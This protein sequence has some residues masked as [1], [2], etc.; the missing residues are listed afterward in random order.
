MLTLDQIDLEDNPLND[1]QLLQV[2]SELNKSSYID[3]PQIRNFLNELEYPLYFLDFETFGSAIP[4]FDN[5]RPYQQLVFQ[6]SLHMQSESG[7]IEHKEYLAE[8]DLH[9]DPR[10]G[11]IDKLMADCGTQG[12]II[13]YNVGFEKGR[14][15]DLIN[16]FPEF[17]NEISTIIDRLKDLMV[18]FQKK[19]YYTPEMKGSYS[20][21]NVLPALV[22]ELSYQDLEIQEGSKASNVFTQMVKGEFSGDIEKTRKALLEYCKMDTLGM[23]EILKVLKNQF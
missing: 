3:R 11:F 1:N 21:K 13:V 8:A 10:K 6:Y 15:N 7:F 4:L 17:E 18:P 9:I 20:I 5:S 2:T 12:D 23:V 14:L 22:P 19:W 16:L